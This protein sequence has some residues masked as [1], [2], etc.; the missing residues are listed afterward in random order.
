MKL[1]HGTNGAWVPNIL[2]RGLEPR[3]TRQARN[4]WKHVPHQ[5]NARCVYLTDSYAPHFAFNATRGKN[6][7]CAVV[8][9]ESDRLNPD[10]LWADEDCLEQ[11]SRDHG[12]DLC[13][14]G[15]SM[16]QRTLHYRSLQFQI[17][18]IKLHDGTDQPAWR[19]SLANLGT[20]SHQGII[21]P[22]A[23]TRIAVW[24]DKENL[25][26]HFVFDPTISVMNQRFC[27][28][29]YRALMAKLFGDPITWEV[30]TDE[31][32]EPVAPYGARTVASF[33]PAKIKGLVIIPLKEPKA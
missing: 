12:K 33:D 4:N 5:S 28:D 20:C 17:P 3:G 27:G 24:P 1:Y 8:E 14:V 6:P 11:V 26:L 13:P 31:D 22:S 25:G 18:S 23:I 10:N 30:W 2:K 29:M 9:V 21:P 16:S 7:K 15:L 19:F 32:G